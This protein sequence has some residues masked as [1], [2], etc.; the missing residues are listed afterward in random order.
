MTLHKQVMALKLTVIWPRFLDTLYML[1]NFSQVHLKLS[2]LVELIPSL[3]SSGNNVDA[4]NLQVK[5]GYY[6]FTKVFQ[7]FE[8]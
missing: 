6:I 7:N 4:E 2:S 5:V 1:V 3:L 8:K